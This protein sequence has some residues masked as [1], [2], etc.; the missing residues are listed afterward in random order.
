MTSGVKISEARMASITQ[1]TSKGY[2]I[3]Q[4]KCRTDTIQQGCFM[5]L[6]GADLSDSSCVGVHC[7]LDSCNIHKGGLVWVACQGAEEVL[8]VVVAG[9]APNQQG[10]GLSY[11]HTMPR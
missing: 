1:R 7:L 2:N 6:K 10:A 11:L 8:E 9:W 3:M 4:S 5:H